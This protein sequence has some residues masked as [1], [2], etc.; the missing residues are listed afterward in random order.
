M[1][2]VVQEFTSRLWGVYLFSVCMCGHFSPPPT[3]HDSY[4]QEVEVNSKRKELTFIAA[5]MSNW[6]CCYFR[7]WSGCLM[8]VHVSSLSCYITDYY[9][10]LFF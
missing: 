1:K 7:C 2:V 10:Y 3:L 4:L 5:D 6:I 8:C 9:Y